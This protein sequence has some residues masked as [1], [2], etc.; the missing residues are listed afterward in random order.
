MRVSSFREL[1]RSILLLALLAAP[2]RSA[3]AQT[4]RV[5]MTPGHAANSFIPAEALGAGIDRLNSAATDKLFTEPVLNAVLAAGW[6]TVSYR[7]N[8]ELHIEAWHWNPQGTWSDPAGKGYFTGNTDLGAPIRHSYGYFLPHRGFT[9]NDGAEA[10]GYS[11]MTDG[12]PRSYSK[13]NPYL[14]KPFTGEED[15]NNPQWV[16]LDLADNHASMQFGSRGRSRYAR[17]YR[18][19][20]WTGE[21]DEAGYQG[22]LDHILRRHRQ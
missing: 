9:R 16:I 19:E 15:A 12:D 6:Q 20:Y 14:T 11:Q 2:L 21:D 22:H 17:R 1:F 5:D 18:V 10:N 4:V 7:Q 13:S 8:T 3:S